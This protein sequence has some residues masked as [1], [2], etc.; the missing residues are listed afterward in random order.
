MTVVI[1]NVKRR[2]LEGYENAREPGSG[3][4]KP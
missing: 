1:Y 2:D 3:G 4:R